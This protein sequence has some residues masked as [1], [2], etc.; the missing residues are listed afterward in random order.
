LMLG[1]IDV[2]QPVQK[3]IFHRRYI[4]SEQAHVKKLP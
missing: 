2:L 3:H 1:V 4:L